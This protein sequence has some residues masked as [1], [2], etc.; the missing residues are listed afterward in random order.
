MSRVDSGSTIIGPILFVKETVPIQVYPKMLECF[1][2]P[3]VKQLQPLVFLQQGGVLRQCKSAVRE[4]LNL[5]FRGR[6]NR[7]DVPNPR[8]PRSQALYL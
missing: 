1:V 6:R 2:V 5:K 8:H 3:H 4:F 7:W